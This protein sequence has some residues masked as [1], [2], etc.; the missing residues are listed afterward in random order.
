MPVYLVEHH[1][2]FSRDDKLFG[3][4]LYQF[5]STEGPMQDYSD[6]DARYIFFTR[7]ILEAI[8]ALGIKPDIINANDW[9]TGLLPVY[10]DIHYANVPELAQARS[11][12]TIHNLAYQGRFSKD[13]MWTARLGWNLFR[14][15]LLEF[16]DGL[17][18]MKAGIVAADAVTTVSRRYA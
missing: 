10:L 2:Y 3:H 14:H 16:H 15:D 12:F 7:A 4:T 11:V 9:Q 18:F 17:N 5:K 1:D 13:T 8:P 6:N